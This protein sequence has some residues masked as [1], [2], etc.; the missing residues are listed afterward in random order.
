MTVYLKSKF[1]N[2]YYTWVTG[3]DSEEAAPSDNSTR[4]KNIH[5]ARIGQHSTNINSVVLGFV[6]SQSQT[7]T[8]FG[9]TSHHRLK[10]YQCRSRFAC[11]NADKNSKA[12]QE[13]MAGGHSQ[14]KKIS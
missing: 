3:H 5:I 4:F 10:L 7:G 13:I 8:T 1:A 14:C 9:V 11:K 12:A 6:S 2:A